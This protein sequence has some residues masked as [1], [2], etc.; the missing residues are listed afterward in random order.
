MAEVKKSINLGKVLILGKCFS[1][2]VSRF[3]ATFR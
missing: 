1:A 3:I 2:K